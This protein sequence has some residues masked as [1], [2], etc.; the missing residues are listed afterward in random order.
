V[1]GRD[2]IWYIMLAVRWLFKHILLFIKFKGIL[3]SEMF[4]GGVAGTHYMIVI[5]GRSVPLLSRCEWCFSLHC[6][7]VL[8]L[9]SSR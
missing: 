4:R 2:F 8:F 9:L 6:A 3:M 5:I 1:Y 7:I